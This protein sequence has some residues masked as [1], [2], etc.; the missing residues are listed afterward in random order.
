M[1]SYLDAYKAVQRH[2]IVLLERSPNIHAIGVGVKSGEPIR[3]AKGDDFSLTAVVSRKKARRELQSEQLLMFSELFRGIVGDTPLQYVE[4]NVIESGA[5]IELHSLQVPRTQRGSYNGGRPILDMQKFFNSLKCGVGITNP[6]QEYPGILSVGTLGVFLRDGNGNLF[7]LS[8]NH[9]IGRS[10]SARLG[11]PIVQAGTLDLTDVELNL[12]PTESE[13]VSQL[14]IAEFTAAVPIVR[15]ARPTIHFNR[16]DAAIARVTTI[17]RSLAEIHMLC[18][19]GRIMGTADPIVA[20]GNGIPNAP[21]RV[22]KVGRT[23]GFTQGEVAMLGVIDSLSYPGGRAY[24]MDQIMIEPTR[25]NGGAFSQP[26]DSGSVV[27]SD[28]HKA[29]GLLFA[30]SP[31]ST[32]VNPIEFVLAELTSLVGTTLSVVTSP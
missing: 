13:L 17:A 12:M 10:D 6:T 8:N 4:T 11:E 28:D 25:D 22:Y 5:P 31:R 30:G 27:L 16:V 26:G 32:L 15:S 7:L 14:K 3:A 1:A 23:T 20:D 9:V 18:Y 24:F 21:A 19:G 29:M 2:G